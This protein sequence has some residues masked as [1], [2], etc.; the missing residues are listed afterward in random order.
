MAY[1]HRVE[2]I[3]VTGATG[4][5]GFRVVL[6]LLDA[7]IAVTV[8]TTPEQDGV[9]A[10]IADRLQIL[11]ADIW[12]R[13]SL[14]GLS[15]GQ[16]GIIHLVGSTK[17]D[18]SRGLTYQQINLVSARNVI[19]M[20]ISD[21]VLNCML[22]SAA[23]LPGMMPS[24][25]IFSKREAEDYL[26][27]SGLQPLIVRAPALFEPSINRP[28]LSVLELGAILPP[29]RWLIS[30][31]IPLPVDIAARGIAHLALNIHDYAGR[32]YYANDL[33]KLARRSSASPNALRRQL[34]APSRSE[35]DMLEDVPFGWLPPNAHPR[36]RYYDEDNF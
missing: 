7:D 23:A 14:K 1:K 3:L 12:S 11:H 16:D 33:R 18:P 28:L 6:A 30:Q 34:V 25:Y 19:G 15:R 13:A 8:I 29:T 5:L 24:Q 32:I 35:G 22:L 4:F 21:G 26:L 17:A 36:P 10:P 27:N 20:A 9:L 2:R 31:Y